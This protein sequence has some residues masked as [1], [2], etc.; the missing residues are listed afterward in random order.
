MTET[1]GTTQAQAGN[2]QAEPAERG[3]YAVFE[4]ADGGLV[5]P[6]TSGLC[7]ACA[8]CGCGE[9]A[10]PLRVPGAMVKLA[11]AAAEGKARGL[12]GRLR[13]MMAL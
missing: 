10:E 5:I 13:G 11:R 2:P 4:Q 7:A 8:A 3:R 1:P 9:Q 12:A 6:R